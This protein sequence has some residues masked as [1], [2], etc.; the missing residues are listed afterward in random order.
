MFDTVYIIHRAIDTDRVT[1]ELTSSILNLSGSIQQIEPEP[2][3]D[4]VS[5]YI[6][7]WT[8]NVNSR[9][10][11]ISLF[12]TNIKLLER[13]VNQ[14]L[15]N[16]LI[17]EDDAIFVSGT[18]TARSALKRDLNED[19]WVHSLYHRMWKDRNIGA[20]AN[21]YPKWETTQLLLNKL[22]QYSK[23][24]KGR[25][26]A[27]DIELDYMKKKYDLPFKYTNHF[28]HPINNVSTLGN[29]KYNKA[30]FLKNNILI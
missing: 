11:V 29:G 19:C 8:K 17:L 4:D 27:W 28:N 14:K 16:V 24:K 5:S 26:R 22:K 18:A 7:M 20:V 12:D 9:K 1:S 13:I 25:H 30:L 2:I 10:A 3:H 21:Y 23:E 15:N 6:C